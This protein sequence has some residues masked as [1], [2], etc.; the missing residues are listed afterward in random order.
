MNPEQVDELLLRAATSHQAGQLQLAAELYAKVLGAD[1]TSPVANHNLGVLAMQTGKGLPTALPLFA[2]AWQ[3]DPGHQQHWLSYLRALVQ[4]GDIDGARRVH[5]DGSQRGLRG[6]GIEALQARM[7]PAKPAAAATPV[8]ATEDL[9]AEQ[10]E[11]DR[12]LGGGLPDA[13]ERLARQLTVRHPQHPLGWKALGSAMLAQQRDQEALPALERAAQLAPADASILTGLGEALQRLGLSSEAEAAYRKALG[14]DPRSLAALVGLAA[15]RIK[16]FRYADAEST[17]RQA[18]ALAPESAQAWLTLGDAQLG[19]RRVDDA[20]TSYQRALALRPG[21]VSA[22]Q[23]LGTLHYENQDEDQLI[24]LTRQMIIDAPSFVEAHADLGRILMRGGRLDEAIEAFR[25]SL[26]LRPDDLT[27]REALLFCCN[28][29]ARLS[30]QALFDEAVAYGK[31]VRA[32]ARPYHRWTAAAPPERLRVGLVS[33]DLREHPVA[34]FLES[35][36]A[37]SDRRRIEWFVYSTTAKADAVSAR[38]RGHVEQW[39]ILDGLGDEE[40]ARQIHADGVHVLIDL[41]GHSALNALA[42]FA[43]RPAPV[44]VSWLGYFATTGPSEIDYLLADPMSVP[45]SDRGLFTESIWH[46]PKTRLCFTVPDAAPDVA[47]PPSA[48]NGFTTFGSFQTLR[49]LNDEVLATWAEVLNGDEPCRM[50][51]QN[52]ELS[53]EA[54]R[55]AFRQRAAHA[56]IALSRLDLHGVESRGQYL[57][58]YAEVDILLDS[59]PFPGG[60]TTCEGLWMGVPTVTLQG[61]NLVGRQGACLMAAAGLSDWIAGSRADYL[62][63]ARRKAADVVALSELRKDMRARLQTSPLFDAQSFARSLEDALWSMWQQKSTN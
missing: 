36:L 56:G 1:P 9:R 59:F 51:V 4:S 48:S 7:A 22:Y 24:A 11:L 53:T 37:N 6:P 15:A 62:A 63:L 46:L 12:L 25:V 52:A 39:R 32:K 14:V 23:K 2:R 34:F 28:Y 55:A 5:A 47:P 31:R 19:Q 10:A 30:P 60:T 41:A 45:D 50:R 18:L 35:V 61:S 3:S 21:W 29:Q 26:Q 40:R 42:V 58:Q 38:L 44:Q 17:C 33:G 49:K 54:G 16:A 57:Q 20:A 8:T 27:T 43:W 13:A